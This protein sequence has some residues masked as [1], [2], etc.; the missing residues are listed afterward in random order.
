MD[1]AVISQALKG[2]LREELEATAR[3]VL[4][5]KNKRLLAMVDGAVAAVKAEAIARVAQGETTAVFALQVG[6]D[7]KAIKR[8]IED[9]KKA[10]PTLS[11]LCLSFESD[12][13]TAF[14]YAT[15]EAQAKGVKANEWVGA[16]LSKLGGRGGGKPGLAQGSASIVSADASSQKAIQNSA[17]EYVKGLCKVN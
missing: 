12:K 4:T 15:D 10:A 5:L 7:A 1:R 3:A 8:V 17:S 11:F 13:V 16:V 9:I 14:A 2:S 6:S